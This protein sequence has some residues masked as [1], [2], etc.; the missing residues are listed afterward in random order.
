MLTRLP[1]ARGPSALL[2]VLA[3]VFGSA[4]SLR[5]E[6]QPA[7]TRAWFGAVHVHTSYSFDAFTNGTVTLPHHAYEW[8]RG[9]AIPGG[10]G[11]PDLKILRPLDFYAVSD[12]AEYMG[13]F[14]QMANPESP[15]SE[16]DLAKRVTSKE[17]GVA[18]QAFAELLRE[19]SAG[20]KRPELSD[21][22]ISRPIWKE[23]V[24]TADRYYEP[25]RFTTF[26]A[27]EWTSNPGKR[28]LHRVVVFA[29]SKG[30]PELPLS[31]LDSDDPEALWRWMDVARKGG[32]TLIAIP[33][34]ANAS[35]GLMF[36]VEN[37]V[38]QPLTEAYIATRAA[39]EPLYEVSQIKGTS[40]THPD[41]SPND[42]FAGF[43]Q[44]DYTLSADSERPTHRKG[45]FARQALLD[46]LSLA[47][48]G[49]GN[50][51]RFGLIGDS[52]T[53]NAAASNEEDNY[54]GKF[55]LENDRR[56]RLLGA[57]GLTPGQMQQVREFSS[58]GLAGVWAP[59]N[60]REAIFAAMQ[61]KETFGTSGP[62][63]QLRFFGGWGFAAADAAS[64]ELA[65]NGY[66]KGVPMG[67]TLA[68]RGE[69]AAPSFLI[70]AAKDPGSGN[71]DRVQVIKGWV[72]GA[73][74]QHEKIHDVVWSGDRQ[75][76]TSGKLPPV[77][78]S[79]D[80]KKAT[81][82]NDI[83]SAQ[84]AVAWT[85]PDFDPALHAFYYARAIEIPTPRWSTRD[86]AVLGV[87]IPAGLPAT[88]QERAWSSPI[89]YTPRP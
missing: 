77:G 59:E 82:S 68:P 73:G 24:D 55:A 33:H 65:A 83:G 35:D 15:L 54:T 1:A 8:A 18:M 86:A 47:Q 6:P 72:D 51:F 69:S 7:A 42:E 32:A 62:R 39:N 10:G 48:G 30:V 89:W 87:E 88:I 31:S 53:H 27:F 5:A 80:V 21:P 49:K 60:T 37:R 40:E 41:L 2:A 44:W 16:L 76:D 71:L 79:V 52:D 70:A 9:K 67:G 84:L 43:E 22:K 74:R 64:A 11:G 29:D 34:N 85:D 50:P 12:H 61:R 13:V 28:N 81:Y 23:I 14:R 75:P 78:S 20:K 17:P 57:P 19:I 38:G 45:S 63:I 66:R 46:G 25:G 4:G 36:S 3:L 56:R 26:P 58:G